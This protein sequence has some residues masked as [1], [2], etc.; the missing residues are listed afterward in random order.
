MQ[1][2]PFCDLIG[3]F[4]PPVF[5]RE[6]NL[7]GSLDIRLKHVEARWAL[8]SD[9]PRKGQA[10]ETR[11]PRGSADWFALVPL[12]VSQGTGIFLALSKSRWNS[13]QLL[14]VPVNSEGC[15]WPFHIT[16]LY[17]E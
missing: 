14:E 5:F 2:R 13:L 8:P 9:H 10:L 11:G 12:C 16:L 4:I 1:V 17:F 7:E 3:V 15:D 6:A